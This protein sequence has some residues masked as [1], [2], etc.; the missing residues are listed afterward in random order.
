M[1]NAKNKKER[2]E[3]ALLDDLRPKTNLNSMLRKLEKLF[4]TAETDEDLPHLS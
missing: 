1:N 4:W 3:R 2:S